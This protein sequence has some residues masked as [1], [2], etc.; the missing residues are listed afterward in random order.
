MSKQVNVK[1]ARNKPKPSLKRL[2]NLTGCKT[3]HEKL[4]ALSVHQM[5]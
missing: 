5:E 2:F 3:Q 1:A 4:N